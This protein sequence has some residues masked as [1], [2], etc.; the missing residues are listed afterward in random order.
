LAGWHWRGGVGA[1]ERAADLISDG[2]IGRSFWPPGFCL[3]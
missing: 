3:G 1:P 2:L